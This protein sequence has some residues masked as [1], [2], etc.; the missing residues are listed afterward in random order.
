MGKGIISLDEIT[1]AQKPFYVEGLKE[2]LLNVT[3]MCDNGYNVTFQ[4]KYCEIWKVE[5]GKL[6]RKAVMTHNNVYVFDGSRWIVTWKKYIKCGF[7]W[8]IWGM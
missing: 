1:K 7:H 5:N 2:N 3:Q 6:V 4:S 8:E